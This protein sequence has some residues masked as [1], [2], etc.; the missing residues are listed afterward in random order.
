MNNQGG[1]R[2]RRPN[3]DRA[4][5]RRGDSLKACSKPTGTVRLDTPKHDEWPDEVVPTAAA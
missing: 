3:H 2:H 1:S 5:S 4:L